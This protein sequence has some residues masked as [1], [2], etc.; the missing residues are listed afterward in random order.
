MS[1]HGNHNKS[2]CDELLGQQKYHDWVVTTAFYSAIHFIDHK[3]FPVKLENGRW[4]RSI[5]EAQKSIGCTKH[6]CR[7][8]LVDTY[9]PQMSVE[10]KFLQSACFNARYKDYKVAPADSSLSREH[11]EHIII[12]CGKL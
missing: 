3:M 9:M 8:I 7:E 1:E 11:L 12:E 5:S 2:L 4:A 10:F 6:Q